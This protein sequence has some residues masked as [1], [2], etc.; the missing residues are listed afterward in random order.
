MLFKSFIVV[1]LSI[2]FLAHAEGE[3][4][5]SVDGPQLPPSVTPVPEL[6][7][8]GSLTSLL[9]VGM[10]LIL[11]IGAI[12]VVSWFVKRVGMAGLGSDQYVRYLGG[13]SVGQRERV[14]LIQVGETQMVVGV[15]PG[16]VSQPHV[17]EKPLVISDDKSRQSSFAQ[18]LAN[19]LQQGGGR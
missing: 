10:M 1:F 6:I 11:V 14:V 3:S 5:Q 4:V 8:P 12:L 9:Q 19:A 18:K 7:E 16:H 15:A 2:P 13:V 17:L